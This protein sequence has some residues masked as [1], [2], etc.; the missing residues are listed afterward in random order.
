MS[1]PSSFDLKIRE[2]QGREFAALEVH[3]FA[4]IPTICKKGYYRD[5]QSG[6]REVVLRE[7]ACYIRSRHKPETVEVSSLEH[8]REL[9]DL[10]T[11][12][13]VR[14]FVTQAQKAGMHLSGNS[15]SHDQGLFEQEIGKWT[16]PLI[17]KIQS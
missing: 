15:D 14:K 17:E 1:P 2:F 8:M 11:E 7:G 5:H 16:S 6:H 9:I 13:G 4:D 3:E 10:A 12:K